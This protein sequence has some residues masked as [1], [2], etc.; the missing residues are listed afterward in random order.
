MGR[1]TVL[2]LAT[3]LAMVLLAGGVTLAVTPTDEPAGQGMLRNAQGRDAA[4]DA[5]LRSLEDGSEAIAAG[6]A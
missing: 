4:L 2:L 6:W 5:S 1:H 3:M